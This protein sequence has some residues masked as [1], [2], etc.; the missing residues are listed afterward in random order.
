MW[1]AVVECLWLLYF[2]D[3]QNACM[4]MQVLRESHMQTSMLLSPSVLTPAAGE[5]SLSSM[6]S[7]DEARFEGG[8]STNEPSVDRV[9]VLSLESSVL[10]QQ[11]VRQVFEGTTKR[12]REPFIASITTQECQ[13]AGTACTGAC[14]VCSFNNNKGIHKMQPHI[15]CSLQGGISNIASE[16]GTREA[17]GESSIQGASRSPQ[18]PTPPVQYIFDFL[19]ERR[20]A[21][22]LATQSRRGEL[23]TNCLNAAVFMLAVLIL[24]TDTCSFPHSHVSQIPLQVSFVLVFNHTYA[25]VHG[26][27]YSSWLQ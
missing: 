13:L 14:T 9:C 5:E 12:L 17:G 7:D 18:E 6:D 23:A 1:L 21:E 8:S 25:S 10:T 20:K 4:C 16:T 22:V 19:P 26:L 27:P 24:M 11:A 2:A 15:A 3:V